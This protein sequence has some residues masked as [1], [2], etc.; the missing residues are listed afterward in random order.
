MKVKLLKHSYTFWRVTWNMHKNLVIFLDFLIKFLE[1][2][3]QRNHWICDR[4]FQNFHTCKMLHPKKKKRA[5]VQMVSPCGE[6][7]PCLSM[8]VDQRKCMIMYRHHLVWAYLTSCNS[9]LILF[10]IPLYIFQVYG[11]FMNKVL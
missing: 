9:S 2:Y 4:K 3:F 10:L 7:V 11:V 1:I 8:H 5:N 6:G